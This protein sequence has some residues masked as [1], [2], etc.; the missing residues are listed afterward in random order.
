MTSLYFITEVAHGFVWNFPT[1]VY[2]VGFEGVF[3]LEGIVE[4]FQKAKNS[5][6]SKYYAL[7]EEGQQNTCVTS[8]NKIENGKNLISGNFYAHFTHCLFSF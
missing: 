3:G 6:K 8:V 7:V 4:I 2:I 1:R 5:R